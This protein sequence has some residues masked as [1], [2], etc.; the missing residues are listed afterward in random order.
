MC[1]RKK[2]ILISYDNIYVDKVNEIIDELKE[3]SDNIIILTQDEP[4]EYSFVDLIIYI[5][6]NST[7][8]EVDVNYEE[9]LLVPIDCE[10]D[11]LSYIL[12]KRFEHC[13]SY[14]DTDES[15]LSFLRNYILGLIQD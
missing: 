10:C 7:L 4:F 15:S 6:S 11:E 14:T 12:S 3:N 1:N 2:R 8:I 5:S 9:K 13:C